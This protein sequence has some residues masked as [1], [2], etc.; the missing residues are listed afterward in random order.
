M[1]VFLICGFSR[2]VNE[3]FDNILGPIGQPMYV[4]GPATTDNVFNKINHFKILFYIMI[5]IYTAVTCDF[6]RGKFFH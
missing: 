2:N 6:R 4:F 1:H 5:M 3:I